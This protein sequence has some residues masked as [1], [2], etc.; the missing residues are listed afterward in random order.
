M[1]DN[2]IIID[3]FHEYSNDIL[4]FLIYYTG[5]TDSEDMV[6][7]TF[8][9]ALR[10][11]NTFNELSNPKTWLFSIARNV[12]IDEMR[13]QKKEKDKQKRLSN[14]YEQSN[15]K[16][17][18]EIYRLNET[19]KEIYLVIQTLKQNYRDVLILK[20]IKELSVKETADILHWSEN[21]VNVTYHRALKVLERKLGGFIDE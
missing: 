18:E 13:K 20:G 7:E 21:K 14:S 12:A 19:N 4:H 5:R 17:P 11:L 9:K 3:W 6:Q 2:D 15:I 16:S 1:A 8:I 10:G